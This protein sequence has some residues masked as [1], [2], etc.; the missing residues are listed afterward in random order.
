MKSPATLC[1]QC[2]S[3]IRYIG[4]WSGSS[5]CRRRIVP[6]F[7]GVERVRGLGEHSGGLRLSRQPVLWSGLVEKK[8]WIAWNLELEGTM[9]GP[10]KRMLH[11]E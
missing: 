7:P 6:L 10:V 3:H 1:A 4:C 8:G 9:T 2:G 5:K 11:L